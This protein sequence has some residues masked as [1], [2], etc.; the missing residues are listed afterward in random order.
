MSD[1]YQ[2]KLDQCAMIASTGS[3]GDSYDNALA[4]S[5][6]GAY[7]VKLIRERTFMSVKDLEQATMC[8]VT[9]WNTNR[10]HA[11]LGFKSSATVEPEYYALHETR[12]KLTIK[13]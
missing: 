6:N 12:S 13:V 8:W 1:E 10:L 3:I 4:E 2:S 7:K 9:W 11:S 5:V